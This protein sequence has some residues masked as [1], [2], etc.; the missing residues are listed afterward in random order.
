MGSDQSFEPQLQLSWA[1][2]VVVWLSYLQTPPAHLRHP[3]RPCRRGHRC[4]RDC[5]LDPRVL[6]VDAGRLKGSHPMI[7][8]NIS[9]SVI[10][11]LSL[12]STSALFLALIS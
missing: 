7:F 2:W 1:S 5:L 4:S 9:V 12:A 8:T 11:P 3:R 6:Q 10:A